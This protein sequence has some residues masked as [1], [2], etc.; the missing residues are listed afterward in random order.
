M[1]NG[2]G[3]TQTEKRKKEKRTRKE[4]HRIERGGKER[5]V[6]KGKGLFRF[7]LPPPWWHIRGQT[8]AQMSL[9]VT[10]TSASADAVPHPP[11]A[12]PESDASSDSVS[13]LRGWRR[14]LRR[15]SVQLRSAAS[16]RIN[17]TASSVTFFSIRKSFCDDESFTKF[18]SHF[19]DKI[20]Q[21]VTMSRHNY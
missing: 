9:Q 18:S 11:A 8:F 13:S 14:R 7:P 17:A 1:T 2:E 5:G 10:S 12:L 20:S 4:A 19:F 16:R 6:R 3:T 15:S 21:I